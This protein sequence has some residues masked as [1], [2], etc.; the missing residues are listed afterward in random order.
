M[1][2]NKLMNNEEA[3]LDRI[4]RA[5]AEELRRLRRRHLRP[6]ADRKGSP[7]SVPPAGRRPGDEGPRA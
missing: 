4:R 1:A 7:S 3:L 6:L 2:F 5:T